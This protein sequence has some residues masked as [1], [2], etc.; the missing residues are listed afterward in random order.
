MNLQTT[1][2]AA[3]LSHFHVSNR[4]HPRY[5]LRSPSTAERL[6]ELAILW[7]GE[8]GWVALEYVYLNARL[9]V[10]AAAQQLETEGL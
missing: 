8:P 6:G 5:Q 3:H 1:D 2:S 10:R 4:V 7:M 9:A